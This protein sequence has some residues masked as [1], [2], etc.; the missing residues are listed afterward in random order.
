MQAD[1]RLCPLCQLEVEDEIHFVTN[2][3]LF[4]TKR[5]QFFN[6]IG[7]SFVNFSGMSDVQKF[8]WLFSNENAHFIR[9]L[10]VFVY[11]CYMQCFEML[12]K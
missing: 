9:E 2:C 3:S 8:I 11:D 4:S 5:K 7:K 6:D 12:R 1:A 10:S